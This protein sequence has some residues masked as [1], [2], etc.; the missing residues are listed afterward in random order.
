MATPLRITVAHRPP[1]LFI[2][3]TVVDANG[4]LPQT[5]YSG[6]LVDLVSK[7]LPTEMLQHQSSIYTFDI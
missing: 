3:Q 5:A 6:Y 2:D 4:V 7:V 1:L